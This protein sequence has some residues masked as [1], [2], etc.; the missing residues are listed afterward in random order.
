MTEPYTNISIIQF[1]NLTN[2]ATF[3]ESSNL[4]YINDDLERF[5]SISVFIL[6]SFI[7]FA[8]LIGNGLVVMG[9]PRWLRNQTISLATKLIFCSLTFHVTPLWKVVAANPM[10]RS[11]TNILIIN[12]AISDLLFVIFCKDEKLTFNS[13]TRAG[14]FRECF[15]Q[16]FETFLCFRQRYFSH[17]CIISPHYSSNMFFFYF[18]RRMDLHAFE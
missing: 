16:Y 3:N 18:I 5:V 13:L 9:K 14:A 11:T 7:F 10:M 8:G 1:Q 12:L 6:F 15:R 17:P 2:N 4:V